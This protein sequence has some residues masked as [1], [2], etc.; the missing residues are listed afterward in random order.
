MDD[1]HLSDEINKQLDNGTSGNY[2]V[3]MYGSKIS[4]LS[5]M[6]KRTEQI[7]ECLCIDNILSEPVVSQ[8]KLSDAKLYSNDR[9]ARYF[10]AWALDQFEHFAKR[11]KDA[12]V[13]TDEST[14]R[15]YK[16]GFLSI[17]HTEFET[18]KAYDYIDEWYTA[19]PNGG[20]FNPVRYKNLFSDEKD[21]A[22]AVSEHMLC[23]YNKAVIAGLMAYPMDKEFNHHMVPNGGAF[24]IQYKT[25]SDIRD[26]LNSQTHDIEENISEMVGEDESMMNQQR[27]FVTDERTYNGGMSGCAVIYSDFDTDASLSLIGYVKNAITEAIPIEKWRTTGLTIKSEPLMVTRG[28]IDIAKE[29]LSSDMCYEPSAFSKLP[30]QEQRGQ[31]LNEKLSPNEYQDDYVDDTTFAFL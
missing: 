21:I 30:E 27:I 1:Y 19:F 22:Y 26:I 31:K 11:L 12:S 17:L 20:Y 18:G 10:G 5:P 15:T 8:T 3:D 2:Y 14:I 28:E 25:G 9:H 29:H 24:L 23:G 6:S 4:K 13:P 7:T 16:D